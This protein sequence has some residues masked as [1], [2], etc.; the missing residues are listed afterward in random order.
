M[1]ARLTRREFLYAFLWAPAPKNSWSYMEAGS[2][3]PT[4]RKGSRVLRSDPS[5][6]TATASAHPRKV[7]GYLRGDLESGT[8]ITIVGGDLCSSS[9]SMSDESAKAESFRV[10]IA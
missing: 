5:E 10:V 2:F 8:V 7:W 6:S 9:R 3:S 4:P 1:V